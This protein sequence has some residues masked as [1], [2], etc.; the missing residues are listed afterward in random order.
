M[1]LSLITTERYITMRL[2][3]RKEGFFILR[4]AGG[5][6]LFTVEGDGSWTVRET[7]AGRLKN[8]QPVRLENGSLINVRI[9]GDDIQPAYLYAE[10]TGAKYAKFARC[11]TPDSVEY[12]V[13]SERGNY[14]VCL[15]PHVSGRHCKLI[16]QDRAWSVMDLGS[17]TG[18]FVNGKRTG[19]G[20]RRLAPGDVVSVLNQKFI[21][22][23]GVLAFNAQCLDIQ[24]LKGA[25]RPLKA[26][27]LP[28]D[29]PFSAEKPAV[30]FHRQTRFTSGVEGRDFSVEA[31]PAPQESSDETPAMLSY[32]PALLSGA[33]MLLA[34]MNPLTGLGM[35]ATS[36]LF[37][38]LSHLHGQQ[39]KQLQEDKRRRLY[40][41]YLDKLEKELEEL[42][43]KQ[44]AMLRKQ[45]PDPRD[46]AEK[47]LDDRRLL[48]SRRPEHSDFLS[49]RLG[50]GDIPVL[51]N[52]T[53]PRESFDTVDDPLRDR[54]REFQSK[55]RVLRDVPV[56]LDAGR[57]YSIGISGDAQSR[58]PFAAHL[59][60]QLAMHIGYDVLKLCLLGP[61]PG[62]LAPLRW[63][64]HTW[65]DERTLHLT[66]AG[67][68]E[69]DRLLPA[70][71]S[72]L[73]PHRAAQAGP[74]RN[75]PELVVL[76]TD[77][78]LAQSGVLTRLLFD[79]S[80]ER[81]RI[82]TLAAHSTQLPSRTD[83]AIGVRERL[84]RMVWQ[85]ENRRQTAGFQLDHGLGSLL[86]RLVHM[87]ANT[88]LDIRVG[89]AVMPDVVPFLDLFGVQDVRQLNLLDRWDRADPARTLRAPIG[90]GE[91]GKLCT[92]DVSDRADGPH[93]LIAGTT[94]SG[95]SEL[96]MSYILSMA[97]SYSPEDVSFLLIDYKGGGMAQ[98]FSDLPH[99]AGII[100]N[101]SGSEISRALMSI[102][103]EL[104]RRQ[105]VFSDAMS[106]L[107]MTQPSIDRYRELYRAGKAAEPVPRLLIITDEFAELR[108]QEPEF[109]KELISAARVGRSLGVHLIL[110]T[111]KPSGVVDDQIRSNTNF[112]LCLRVQDAR[113]SQDVLKCPDAA[114]LT[115]A[116]QFYKQVGFAMTKA[117]SAWTGADYTPKKTALPSCGVEILDNTGAVIRQESLPSGESGSAGTQAGAVTKYIAELARRE[118]IR[119]RPLW[120]PVLEERIPLSELRGRYGADTEPWVLE[121]VLGELDDPANQGRALVRVP[122]GA[123]KNTIVYGGTGS[124]KVML[125][126][127]VLE[128][129]MLRHTPE[130]L[131]IYILDYADDG[132][133]AY[134]AAPHVGDV[135]ASGDDE[136]L[137]RLLSYLERE[138]AA[139]KKTL[140]GALT[141]AP[142]PERL[143]STDTCHILVILHNLANLKGRLGD[144][145]G[146]LTALLKDGPHWGVSFL[147]TQESALGLGYQL[148]DRFAQK[149]VLQMDHDE[150][151]S[152]LLGRTGK[153]RPAAI[154]GRGLLRVE[155]GLYE[156]QT[157]SAE[158]KVP[159]LCA[160]LRDGWN[161]PAA[162]PIRVM[163]ERVTREHLAAALDPARP[164]RLP[165]GL[166]PDTL[167]P[168]CFDFG[169]RVVHLVLGRRGDIAGF[170]R[171]LLP[172]A[173]ENGLETVVF[174]PDG[175]YAGL[176]GVDAAGGEALAG[177]IDHM[178]DEC[179]AVR[180]AMEKGQPVTANRRLIAL[181]SVQNILGCLDEESRYS[182]RRIL[183]LARPEWRWTI[184]VCDP[185]Q[186]FGAMRFKAEEK[187]WIS[188][189][190]S[191]A[192][193]LYLGGGVRSQNVLQISGD[194]NTLNQN[195]SFPLGY[196]VRDTEAMRVCFVE[197]G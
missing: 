15:N 119:T 79:S 5:R 186:S 141:S 135:A 51:A 64:P 184:I 107:G 8:G 153:M 147:A 136:K 84:G 164:L 62:P 59:I 170:L 66:A 144:G 65:D 55:P 120:Q 105:R 131:H 29:G 175:E 138:I 150:D 128:D 134:L 19:A 157:A 27:P 70:L 74:G 159:E 146:R 58:Y 67:R 39:Q 76:I 63:L 24:A 86:P 174:D 60:G 16:C 25:V 68:E 192:D 126:S 95:K 35:L 30:F 38:G 36:V 83:L 99:T 176:D 22:L 45:T 85:E 50:R 17:K 189:C 32:G 179:I 106:R 26:P 154:R 82:I 197:E 37:P 34:E 196:T 92:L 97:V 185:P 109:M 172:L 194:M 98:A 181:P 102:Q 9:H 12:T 191:M 49:L 41:E 111:Q 46:E 171:G 129:L 7:Q 151:Y 116:G 3:E 88:M 75:G 115:R 158:E 28:P 132:L 161:G 20:A 42:N 53:F 121:P 155:E 168:V 90:V 23:P 117:Q 143:R 100:T 160:R 193:G 1:V 40:D 108:S 31:P 163:P 69:L 187:A 127:A 140:G 183:E 180:K 130:Q 71:G 152:A 91:D 72:F 77:A 122:L 118:N 10:E 148:A 89:S 112:R 43:G 173:A 137:V 133:S 104:K 166:D 110:A 21:V 125:L 14:F 123:G 33:A 13:G 6:E 52:I 80:Y 169:S 18:T 78:E 11:Q 124:G 54:L 145:L 2:P 101:L 178:L 48:W 81:L 182:L 149:Y 73:D 87:M 188:A 167:E 96:I 114:E 190:V 44:T 165:V 94:G 195:I 4:D 156:F 142:L 113:D 93:G 162:E 61:L 103:S 56:V 139:R 177:T 57:F 47:L